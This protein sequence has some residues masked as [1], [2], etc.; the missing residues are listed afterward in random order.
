MTNEEEKALIA[1]YRI[2]AAATIS[3]I[4]FLDELTNIMNPDGFVRERSFKWRRRLTKLY[5]F[6]VQRGVNPKILNAINAEMYTSI[7]IAKDEDEPQQQ[8]KP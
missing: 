4:E 2:E 8:M 5:K 7:E 1:S 6:Y 3:A